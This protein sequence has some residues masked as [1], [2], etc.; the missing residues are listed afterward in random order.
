[1]HTKAPLLQQL[2]KDYLNEAK[3]MQLATSMNA[4]PWVCN[5]WFASDK[6]LNI[7]WLS[8]V[9]RRHSH[10]VIKNKKVAAA[11]VLALTPQDP[12]RG[13]QLQGTAEV[14]TEQK[15]IEKAISVY[16]G[17][18]FSRKKVAEFMAHKDRPHKFY[19]IKP[20]Q[21]IL[22]DVINFPDNSRQEYTL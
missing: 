8:S 16:A 14:L 2:I 19:R 10:E 6:K 5:V 1:M 22:F 3:M 4:Q 18:I 15:D 13:L 21:F 17:R 12:P 9:T 7:Y 20:S 11:I